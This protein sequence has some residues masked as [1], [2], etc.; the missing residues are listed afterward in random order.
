MTVVKSFKRA[1]ICHQ[2]ELIY[3]NRLDFTTK[4]VQA[5]PKTKVAKT[6][7]RVEKPVTRKS[8][9]LLYETIT[10]TIQA[11]FSAKIC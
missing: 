5:L 7:K 6:D 8:M 2:A 11:I 1:F 3:S 4:L 10:I 9:T